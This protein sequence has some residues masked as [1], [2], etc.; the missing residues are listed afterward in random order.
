[1]RLLLALLGVLHLCFGVPAV[2]APRWFFDHFPGLGHAWT[3]AYPPFN[4]HLMSDVGAAFTTLGVLL[5][6]AAW[7]ADRK[8]TAVVLTGVLVFSL[9]HLVFHTFDHGR[10]AGADLTASLASLVLG[11]AV[12]AAMLVVT[13]AGRRKDEDK[14]PGR[15]GR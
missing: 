2:V 7:I 3:A 9:L 5:V 6:T 10:L 13:L 14:N 11:V 15:G 1:M 4:E 8:V 12:P